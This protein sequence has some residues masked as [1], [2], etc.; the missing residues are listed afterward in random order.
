MSPYRVLIVDDQREV[1]RVL[2]AALETLGADVKVTDVPSGEEAILVISRQPIELLITDVRLPGISGLELKDRAKVRNPNLRMILI[3]GLTETKVRREVEQAGVD[4]YF[5]KPIEMGAFLDTVQGYLGGSAAPAPAAEAAPPKPAVKI[6]KAAPPEVAPVFEAMSAVPPAPPKPSLAERMARLRQEVKALAT[7]LVDERGQVIVRAGDP[8]AGL[9]NDGLLPQL[10]AAVGATTRISL[11]IGV[12]LPRGLLYLPGETQDF[13]LTHV[14]QNV[15]LL[16]VTNNGVWEEKRLGE[17]LTHTRQAARDLL[18]TLATWGVDLAEA[19]T[20]A[21]PPPE[22]VPQ[23][24]EEELAVVLPELDAI[25]G[26]IDAGQL[27]SED[28]NA[29]WDSLASETQSEIA[30][31]DAITFDQARQLGLAPDEN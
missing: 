20:Q 24:G 11:Q 27:K 13:F 28:V 15:G 25:F 14:G 9:E 17:L 19:P 10:G 7:L 4:A 8:P 6:P 5:Y 23:V 12:S 22:A 2:R 30:S 26:K 21:P 29:F 1:R 18:E 16:I 31:A 3:T